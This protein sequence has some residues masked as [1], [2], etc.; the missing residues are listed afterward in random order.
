MHSRNV[1][2]AQNITVET[3]KVTATTKWMLTVPVR[4]HWGPTFDT[5]VFVS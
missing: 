2:V 4:G 3:E 1:E 5:V